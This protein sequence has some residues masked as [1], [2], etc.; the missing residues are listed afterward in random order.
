VKGSFFICFSSIGIGKL[1]SLTNLDLSNNSLEEIPAEILS[2]NLTL[3]ELDLSYNKLT[4]LPDQIVNMMNLTTLRVTGNQ[5]S[6]E[7]LKKIK[8]KKFT[9]DKSVVEIDETTTTT[10]PVGLGNTTS[11]TATPAGSTKPVSSTAH[12]SVLSDSSS[13]A[14]IT[15]GSTPNP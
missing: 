10:T 1:Q 12:L 11:S 3:T 4:S 9:H 15:N 2:L 6:S 7:E 14:L 5:F 8:S 13:P